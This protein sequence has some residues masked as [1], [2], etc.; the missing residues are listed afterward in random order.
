MSVSTCIRSTDSG[1]TWSD[2]ININGP[3][4]D[5]H[6]MLKGLPSEISAVQTQDGSILTLVRP[7]RSLF[8]W[9]SWSTNGGATWTP[10]TRGP[11]PMYAC[12]RA[13]VCTESGAILLGG[14]FPGLA[15][16][17]SRDGG[18]SW[19]CY[20]IDTCAWANGAMI[21]V[22]PDIV[23]F[24]YGGKGELRGQLLK[25]TSEELVPL[26]EMRSTL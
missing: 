19:T 18:M 13:I 23:A 4:H 10:Q 14:R 7:F 1:E 9:E 11:F 12:S 25:V 17:L 16:Q 3:P 22:E 20:R 8:M 24:L 6:W 26:R 15:V 21:E 5:G 2:P